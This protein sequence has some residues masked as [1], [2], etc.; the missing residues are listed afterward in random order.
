MYH[1]IWDTPPILLSELCLHLS[2]VIFLSLKCYICLLQFWLR[3]RII[4]LIA[5]AVYLIL[6]ILFNM[7]YFM[8]IVLTTYNDYYSLSLLTTSFIT[9]VLSYNFYN[10]KYIRICLCCGLLYMLSHIWL[11]Y[12]FKIFCYAHLA[13]HSNQYSFALHYSFTILFIPY[14]NSF[15]TINLF[16]LV[17]FIVFSYH[18]LIP[19]KYIYYHTYTHLLASAV[20]WVLLL[21]MVLLILPGNVWDLVFCIC[22]SEVT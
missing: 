21:H 20:L 4:L 7:R 11:F 6:H 3:H 12:I 9:F 13:R 8:L 17:Y 18:I 22:N 15:H 1:I 14:N 10:V 2:V 19:L 16:Y 5:G